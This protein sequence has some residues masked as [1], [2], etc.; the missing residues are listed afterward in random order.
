MSKRCLAPGVEKAVGKQTRVELWASHGGQEYELLSDVGIEPDMP[1]N[2]AGGAL[3]K[4][5][6]EHHYL[7]VGV[8]DSLADLESR[9]VIARFA[10]TL[11]GHHNKCVTFVPVYVNATTRELMSPDMAAAVEMTLQIR[12]TV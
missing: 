8:G 5:M 1:A 3:L 6:Q 9:W 2:V 4:D 10:P 12:V 11:M 7:Q